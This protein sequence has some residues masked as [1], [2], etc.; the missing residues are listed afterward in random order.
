MTPREAGFLLLT[1]HLGNPERC[2]L[3]TPQLRIL[4][5][6]ARIMDAPEEERELNARDL[7]A[8]GY[9]EGSARRILSLLGDG[10]LLERYLQKGRRLGCL[11]I[12]RL[13]PA[14]PRS[15]RHRLELDAPGCLWAKGDTGLLQEPA[16]SLVGSR[17]LEAPNREFAREV[18]Q[19]AAKQGYVLISGNARGADREGQ[20]ACLAAGGQVIS[21][22]ADNLAEKS[23][24][25]GILYL[26]EEDFDASF[27]TPR[28]LRRNRAIH[29][30]GRAVFVAQ[31]SLET[32]GTWAGTMANLRVGYSPVFCYDDGSEASHRL[33][34]AGAC[35]VTVEELADIPALLERNRNLLDLLQEETQ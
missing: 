8:L 15:L 24:E 28:A 9:T 4:I 7:T 26:S 16:I 33:E 30:L 21:V 27:S 3:T 1:S 34:Q 19:Q 22:I 18:G 5:A 25:T 17:E 11:P 32:G 12:T 35:L 20:S 23:R 31:C 2:P 14:Y 13:S 29:A 10:A 6:S